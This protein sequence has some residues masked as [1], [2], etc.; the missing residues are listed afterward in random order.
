MNDEKGLIEYIKNETQNSED[1][2]YKE[3]AIEKETLT[4][5]YAETLGKTTVIA[6]LIKGIRE[7]VNEQIKIKQMEQILEK[8]ADKKQISKKDIKEQEELVKEVIK[9]M[10]KYITVAKIRKLELSQDDVFYYLYSGFSLVLYKNN[11]FA[12][13]TRENLERSISEPTTEFTIKGPKDAFGE[14]YSRNIGLIRKRLKGENLIVKQFIVGRRSK[15]KVGIMYISDICRKELVDYVVKKIS[16]IQIDGIIDSN[17]IAELINPSNNDSFPTFV[18]T[19]RPDLASFHLLE[20]RIVIVVENTPYVLILP[21]FINDFINNIDDYYQ[22]ST[23]IAFTRIVRYLAFIIA[24]VLPGIYIALITYNQEAIPTEFL[25]SFTSQRTAMPFP[26]FIEA[27]FMMLAFEVLRESDYRIP[28][29]AGSTL[30]IVGALILGDAAVSA[31]IVSSIMII[32]I[33]LSIISSLLI[34]D[35]NM[36]N[37]IRTW[38]FVFL[39]FATIAGLIGIG[40][41]FILFIVKLSG[42]YSF[43]KSFSYPIAPFNKQGMKSEMV[44]RSNIKNLKKRLKILTDNEKRQIE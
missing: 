8:L 21:A 30:S 35:V 13:E 7:I 18:N 42:V 14:S 22:K 32:V 6:N 20:G 34:S 24:I 11:I 17:Y 2:V 16:Q 19:E 12:V 26:A 31:G 25:L 33:A 15:T 39:F 43:G 1:I 44:A 41:A 29:V 38:R 10:D 40:I 5:V 9:K 28:T 36:A 37:A 27:A 23:N 3:I 4:I